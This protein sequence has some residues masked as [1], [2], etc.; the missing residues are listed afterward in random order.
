MLRFY[1]TLVRLKVKRKSS[2]VVMTI[3]FYSTLVRLKV[4]NLHYSNEDY[5][6]FL[7]HIGAIKSLAAQGAVLMHVM[8]LFHIGAIKRPN[9]NYVRFGL[10]GFYSTL[11]RLKV[12]NLHYSNEDY[13]MFLFHIGAIKR[14]FPDRQP[15]GRHQF[16]FHIGAIKRLSKNYINIIINPYSSC[17]VKIYFCQIYGWLPSTSNRANSLG[18]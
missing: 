11:V 13:Y 10:Y 14:A 1:S 8:F 15:I 9:I 6:M 16:L 2:L 18:G 17:Q 3:R 7:F 5:Y 12:F 4:F